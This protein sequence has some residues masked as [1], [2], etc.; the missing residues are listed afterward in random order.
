MIYMHLLSF[1]VKIAIVDNY[2]YENL[3]RYPRWWKEQHTK[4]KQKKDTNM[5]MNNNA[6]LPA[7]NINAFMT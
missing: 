5:T 3:W 7:D 2:E 6:G 4:K 1:R